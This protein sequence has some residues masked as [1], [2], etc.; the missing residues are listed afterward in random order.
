MSWKPASAERNGVGK[1]RQPAAS[2]VSEGPALAPGLY[3]VATPIGN[4]DDVTLRALHVLDAA[5]VVACEDTRITAKLLA[6]YGIRARTTPYYDNNADA[7]RPRLLARLGRGER[8]ALVSDAG[9]P[10]I[11][12][13]GFKLVRAAVAAGH[14]VCPVPGASAPLAALISS[15]L[16]SNRFLFAGFL[17]PR[18]AARRATLREFAAV[19][20]TLVFL[21]SPRRLAASLADMEVVL[22]SR[23]AAVARE[24]TKVFEEVQ[25]APLADLAAA[26]A[27]LGP[28]KGEVVI[29]VG[30]PLAADVP[31]ADV[32]AALARALAGARLREAVDRVSAETGRPRREV[33]ARALALRGK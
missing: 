21:E 27:D 10:L 12:D 13:P 22:G 6:H 18:A 7:A 9:T 26:Y 15:G 33:Y 20:A 23:D 1:R 5:D 14:L 4:L 28:P 16:P 30:P 17:P 32:D 2:A 25:R 3:L 24:L 19:P 29:V 11:S 8:V 31:Q